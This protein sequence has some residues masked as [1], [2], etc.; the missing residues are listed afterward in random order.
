MAIITIDRPG[1]P[2]AMSWGDLERNYDS[3]EEL[4]MDLQ[5]V[6]EHE[7]ISENDPKPRFTDRDGS[8]YRIIVMS[9]E[10]VLCVRV[11]Q[12]YDPASLVLREAQLSQGR[13]IIEFL[14]DA[15]HRALLNARVESRQ[16]AGA[17][18]GLDRV[19]SEMPAGVRL[20][21][22]NISWLAFDEAWLTSVDPAPPTSFSGIAKKFVSW[23]RSGRS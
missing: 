16:F 5:F 6:V 23:L 20:R 3:L 4:A 13:L 17:A 10:V 8:R 12:N 2:I 11:P 9:L 1:M 14:G 21:S 7:Y 22:A 19:M 18:V 15:P